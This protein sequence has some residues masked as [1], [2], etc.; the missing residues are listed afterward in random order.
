[1]KDIWKN[2]VNRNGTRV[3]CRTLGPKVGG[4][5]GGGEELNPVRV[6]FLRDHYFENFGKEPR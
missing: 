1:M 5:G 4:W 3:E 2:A 6:R